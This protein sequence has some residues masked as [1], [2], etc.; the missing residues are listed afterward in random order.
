MLFKLCSVQRLLAFSH[1]LAERTQPH[2]DVL[3]DLHVT[4]RL[5]FVA[6]S[7]GVGWWNEMGSFEPF[8]AI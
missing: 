4:G 3:E 6:C 5:L 1:Q 7:V 8:F 2:A